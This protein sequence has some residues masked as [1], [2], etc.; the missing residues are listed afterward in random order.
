[1]GRTGPLRGDLLESVLELG[2]VGDVDDERRDV[3]HGLLGLGSLHHE[4][5]RRATDH[6]AG[7]IADL[8]R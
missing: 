5:A 1:M 6:V 7:F 8:G 3:G 4:R 2:L